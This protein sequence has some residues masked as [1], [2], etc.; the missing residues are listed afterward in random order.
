ML[1]RGFHEPL[2]ESADTA[3]RANFDL[4][5]IKQEVAA[6]VS[7]KFGTEYESK[8]LDTVAA[9]LAEEMTVRPIR[10]DSAVFAWGF[11]CL[12]VEMREHGFKSP[13][14]PTIKNADPDGEYGLLRFVILKFENQLRFS[15]HKADLQGLKL[16][17][18]GHRDNPPTV[19]GLKSINQSWFRMVDY[20]VRIDSLDDLE[21]YLGCRF[22]RVPGKR[23]YREVPLVEA[24]AF[25]EEYSFSQGTSSRLPNLSEQ[26]R[27]PQD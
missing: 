4:A 26:E 15:L 2:V 24:E 18:E 5:K 21:R 7:E 11:D 19:K 10:D 22:S 27:E 1:K 3:S 9:S 16:Y 14:E 12:S 6:L 17:M 25:D 23:K 13:N 20:W 8:V